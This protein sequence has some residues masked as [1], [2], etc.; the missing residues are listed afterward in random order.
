MT[1]NLGLTGRTIV[2]V[3]TASIKGSLLIDVDQSCAWL[4]STQLPLS[5]LEQYPEQVVFSVSRLLVQQPVRLLN[6]D[7]VCSIHRAT[8]LIEKYKHVYV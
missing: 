8:K 6:Q 4:L 5:S 1:G 2:L 3:P 7:F